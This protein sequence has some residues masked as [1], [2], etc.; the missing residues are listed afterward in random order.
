MLALIETQAP[1]GYLALFALVGA[2]SAGVPIPGQTALIA[3]GARAPRPVRRHARDDHR[4]GRC[5]H[6]RQHRLR[7]WL[8]KDTL[9]LATCGS[10]STRACP[11]ERDQ[12]HLA[13]WPSGHDQV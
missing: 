9:R 4:C 12:M 13:A 1:S 11:W 3:A 7:D 6:G 8:R 10:P 2:W 5:D